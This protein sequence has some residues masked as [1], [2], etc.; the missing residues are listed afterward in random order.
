VHAFFSTLEILQ[1]HYPERLHR[2]YICNPPWIFKGFWRVVYPFIDPVT[3]QKVCFC[4][5][6]DGFKKIVDDMG[7]AEKASHL[8]QCA[9]GTHPISD[10]IST[11]YLAL[12]FNVTYVVN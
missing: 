9:G 8:E 11:E 3:K 1:K 6:K 4:T 10:F 7:G 12:P 2:A 5:G